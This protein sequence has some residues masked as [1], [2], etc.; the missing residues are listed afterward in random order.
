[1]SVSSNVQNTKSQIQII[2]TTEQH[3]VPKSQIPTE[4]QLTP[5]QM[6][7]YSFEV[8]TILIDRNRHNIFVTSFNGT[9]VFVLNDSSSNYDATLTISW[10]GV[11]NK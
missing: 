3:T 11:L 7:E 6:D 9:T 4:I 1:M 2:T 10:I 5:P 8:L